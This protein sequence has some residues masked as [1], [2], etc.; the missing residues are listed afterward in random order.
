M[1]KEFKEFIQ[2]GNVVDMAVGL[3]MGMAFKAIVDSLVNDFIMPFISLLVGGSRLAEKRIILRAGATPEEIVSLNYGSFIQTVLNFLI[4]A[5]V[6]FFMIKAMN[7]LRRKT[8]K[9]E[10][11]AEPSKEESLLTEIRDLLAKK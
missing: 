9:A 3:I 7:K 4:I 2:R 6:I 8:E 10:A 11:V 5:L 1:W